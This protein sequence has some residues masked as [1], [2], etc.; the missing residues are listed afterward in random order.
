MVFFACP[1]KSMCTDGDRS[2]RSPGSHYYCQKKIQFDTTTGSKG[3]KEQSRKR[4]VERLNTGTMA[5]RAFTSGLGKVRRIRTAKRHLP[6][7][8]WKRRGNR[9]ENCSPS[10][11]GVSAPESFSN[12]TALRSALGSAGHDRGLAFGLPKP[13]HL[14]TSAPARK[15]DVCRSMF[16]LETETGIVAGTNPARRPNFAISRNRKWQPLK[17]THRRGSSYYPINMYCIDKL[18]KN[19]NYW[20]RLFNN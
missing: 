19:I 8:F 15:A 16:W 13:P 2:G 3:S 17:K 18:Y 20:Y 11:A 14:L 7:G 6:L 9:S 4:T 1:R 10:L 12:K 5:K